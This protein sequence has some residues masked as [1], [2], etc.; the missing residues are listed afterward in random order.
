MAKKKLIQTEW[1]KLSDIKPDPLNPRTI[2]KPDFKRLVASIKKN[3]DFLLLREIIVDKSGRIKAGNQRYEAAKKAGLKEVPVKRAEQ[4]SEEELKEF[5]I[6][7]NTHS[8]D[9]DIEILANNFELDELRDWDVKLPDL[10]LTHSN[11]P[12]DVDGFADA[13]T[14]TMKFD[15]KTYELVKTKLH[16]LAENPEEAL[17]KLL[18]IDAV[19]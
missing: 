14:I 3:P 12:I 18:L 2:S 19:S 15:S 11:K 6:R 17:L 4:F 1:V 10:N 7:D 5:M 13:M 9:W 8:G 16:E